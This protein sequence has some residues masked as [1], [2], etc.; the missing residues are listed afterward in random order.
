MYVHTIVNESTLLSS[1]HYSNQL[2]FMLKRK[3]PKSTQIEDAVDDISAVNLAHNYSAT[4][5]PSLS[6]KLKTVK[7]TLAVDGHLYLSSL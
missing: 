4:L 2:S 3:G 5:D 7:E 1:R 6:A